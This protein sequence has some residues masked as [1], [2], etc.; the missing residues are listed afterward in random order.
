MNV[1]TMVRL[2]SHRGSLFII[3]ETWVKGDDKVCPRCKGSGRF[4]DRGRVERGGYSDRPVEN[5]RRGDEDRRSESVR[6]GD[7]GTGAIRRDSEGPRVPQTGWICAV[8]E[9]HG[10]A[11]KRF[12][13]QEVPHWYFQVTDEGVEFSITLKR[14]DI[15]IYFSEEEAQAGAIYRNLQERN[16][17][18]TGVPGWFEM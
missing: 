13:V 1:E 9:G 3:K 11:Q 10:R 17:V 7:T 5:G 18:I 6:R 12:V 15:R 14:D 2:L 8:C 4:D 16:E